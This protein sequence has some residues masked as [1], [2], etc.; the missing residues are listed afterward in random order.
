MEGAC[1][2]DGCFNL[3]GVS[4]R[5]H[6]LISGSD[7]KW[8]LHLLAPHDYSKEN[9]QFQLARVQ[10][11]RNRQYCL[12]PYENDEL[13]KCVSQQKNVKLM[14]KKTLMKQIEVISMIKSSK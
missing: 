1:A 11:R 2:H 9:K 8:G 5:K 12:S 6:P 7:G 4:R 10:Y 13:E 3:T 14:K